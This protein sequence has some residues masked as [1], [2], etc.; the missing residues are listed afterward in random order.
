MKGGA[1]RILYSCISILD[2]LSNVWIGGSV[3]GSAKLVRSGSGR[4]PKVGL[5]FRGS[6][7]LF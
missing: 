2:S 5:F 6:G 1:A 7:V 3:V 4:L